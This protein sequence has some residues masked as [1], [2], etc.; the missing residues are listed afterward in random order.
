MN[1]DVG[2]SQHES[3]HPL[4]VILVF[5]MFVE[6]LGDE[7]IMSLCY[8]NY[9]GFVLINL[10]EELINTHKCSWYIHWYAFGFQQYE[11]LGK[12]KPHHSEM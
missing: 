7:M 1:S 11:H 6:H 2:F 8:L 5:F 9:F 12:F 3:T 10:T 4:L